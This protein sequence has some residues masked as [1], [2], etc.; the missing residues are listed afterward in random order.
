M[1]PFGP[2]PAEGRRSCGAD[3]GHAHTAPPR[4]GSQM[5]ACNLDEAV[6]ETRAPRS[7]PSQCPCVP[8]CRLRQ[9]KPQPARRSEFAQLVLPA[10]KLA[11]QPRAGQDKA[12]GNRRSGNLGQGRHGGHR[13]AICD[14]PGTKSSPAARRSSSS[15]RMCRCAPRTERRERR[16]HSEEGCRCQGE[17]EG[18]EGRLWEGRR[19][20]AARVRTLRYC[21]GPAFTIAPLASLFR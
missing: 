8:G 11:R 17:G 1:R 19:Y 7:K 20:W 5:C 21:T 14:K 9:G 13:C 16:G 10:A 3:R 15:R 4:R 2:E 6:R 18:R 12:K